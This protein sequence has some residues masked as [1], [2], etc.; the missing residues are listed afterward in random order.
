M[1]RPAVRRGRARRRILP[2]RKYVPVCES[3]GRS[4]R[5]GP[6]LCLCTTRAKTASDDLIRIRSVS[7]N[8]CFHDRN[9]AQRQRCHRASRVARAYLHTRRGVHIVATA[10]WIQ[11]IVEC[12]VIHPKPIEE[13][14]ISPLIRKHRRTGFRPRRLIGARAVGIIP[15]C[16]A[17]LLWPNR[18]ARNREGPRIR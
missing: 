18:Y 17:P 8:L 10:I 11:S 9:A 2:R 6:H 3:S 15:A 1:R 16:H 13:N 14:P 12:W 5:A 4:R 7:V